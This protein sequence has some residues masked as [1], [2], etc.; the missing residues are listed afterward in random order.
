MTNQ[1]QTNSNNSFEDDRID[2]QELFSFLWEGRKLIVILTTVCFLSSIIFALSLDKYYKSTATLSVIEAVS[3]GGGSLGG[4]AK[5]AGIS[6]QQVG[7]KGPRFIN[8]LRS[9]AFLNY[10][11]ESDESVLPALIAVE[12]YDFESK[13][14]VFDSELYDAANKKW[15]IPKPNY[16]EAYPVYMMMLYTYYHDQRRIIDLQ[17]EHVSPIFAK[18]FLDSI[19]REG[20]KV[21]R[22]FDMQVSIDS[23]EYLNVELAETKLLNIKSSINQMILSQM[24]TKMMTQLGY[25]YVVKIIDPP[26]VPLYPFWPSR[27]LIVI[28]TTLGGLVFGFVLVLLRQY[29]GFNITKQKSGL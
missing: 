4:F 12:S 26:F 7:V 3:G 24:Q 17:F 1:D 20:D 2:L 16:L 14:L 29:I 5:M 11:I 23:L 6:I 18:E 9:R 10:L 13:K 15:L 21:L 22:E 19:I 25:N 8:T 27:R 28:I